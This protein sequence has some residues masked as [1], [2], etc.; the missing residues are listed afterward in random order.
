MVSGRTGPDRADARGRFELWRRS[1]AAD[2]TGSGGERRRSCAALNCSTIRMG[3][4]QRGHSQTAVNRE[5]SRAPATALT[6][7]EIRACNP[8]SL[9]RMSNGC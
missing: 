9:H 4:L 7:N 8:P 6:G 5:C 2:V 1:H 3:P